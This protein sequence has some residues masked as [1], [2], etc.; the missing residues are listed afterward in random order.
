M[1]SRSSCAADVIVLSEPW[2]SAN[3]CHDV[4]GYT[5]FHTYL[6][7]KTVGG[8]T[9]FITNCYTS[10]HMANFSVCH[11]YYE[12]SLVKVLLSNNYCTVI[13]IGVYRPL[14]NKKFQ[15]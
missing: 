14:T 1:Y 15:I 3:T 5:G 7:D 10:T 4:Q 13:I 12:I 8:V 9:V 2:F 11:A 6:A